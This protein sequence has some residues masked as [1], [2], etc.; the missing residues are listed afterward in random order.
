MQAVKILLSCLIIA[1]THINAQSLT[2]SSAKDIVN[3]LQLVDSNTWAINGGVFKSID[4][5]LND[6]AAGQYQLL[7][8]DAQDRIVVHDIQVQGAKELKSNDNILL[9]DDIGP[10][11]DLT[12]SNTFNKGDKTIVGPKSRM[13]WVAVDDSGN[14]SV[15]IDGEAVD[16]EQGVEFSK[17]SSLV[18]VK[19]SD[20]F[21][22][23]NIKQERLIADF[24]GPQFNWELLGP[25]VKQNGKWLAG[26]KAQIRVE[27]IDDV[28]VTSLTLNGDKINGNSVEMKVKNNS[29]LVAEDKL[30]NSSTETIA[31]NVD[32]KKPSI[33]IKI[34][35]QT[36]DTKRHKYIVNTNQD[37]FLTVEDDTSLK[38]A[39]YF[40]VRKQWEP[41]PQNFTF[42]KRGRNFIKVIAEDQFGNK[43][44][45]KLKFRAKND[46]K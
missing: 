40:S 18:T 20:Y 25:A 19:A 46:G 16:N 3:Q 29:V 38:Y 8:K 14:V 7:I 26:S 5:G 42:F 32:D 44:K 37:I 6:L 2:F 30:G 11:I 17:D 27:A 12:W 21:G 41:L 34:D 33:I 35:G 13:K 1:T 22:N 24:Q 43:V 23:E 45:T 10:D 36:L 39:K 31:W 15:Q 28:G 9:I 4:E